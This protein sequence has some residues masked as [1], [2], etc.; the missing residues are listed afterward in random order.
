MKISLLI[1]HFDIPEDIFYTNQL[2][3]K[4][5]IMEFLPFI[6]EMKPPFLQEWLT[7]TLEESLQKLKR[8]STKKTDRTDLLF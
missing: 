6:E 5:K 7:S 8:K 4:T 2:E 3:I 1:Q